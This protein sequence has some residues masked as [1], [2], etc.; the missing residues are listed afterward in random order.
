MS[1]WMSAAYVV[2]N[3]IKVVHG[4][5]SF[6]LICNYLIAVCVGQC[7]LALMIDFIPSVRTFAI[8]VMGPQDDIEKMKRLYGFGAFLDTAGIRFSVALVMIA[9]MLS[10]FGKYLCKKTIWCYIGAFIILTVI[11][12]MIARTTLVGVGLSLLYLI[13]ASIVYRNL[14]RKSIWIDIIG[15]ICLATPIVFY[16]YYTN[17]AI[18]EY[19]RFAFEG[20]FSLFETG[21]WEVGSNEILKS[22]Y[23]FPETLKTWFIGD[24]YFVNPVDIDP[25]YTGDIYG[26]YYMGTDVG[27]LRFIFYFG[28]I[29]LTAFSVF[30]Y[31]AYHICG[32]WY[33]GL[34]DLFFL[35]LAINFIVWFKV[36]TDIFLV[37][38]L[39]LMIDKKEYNNIER[40]I[41]TS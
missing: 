29:G 35:V 41:I 39:F 30:I 1:V 33:P 17:I 26:G 4:Y 9:F 28:L 3:V 10:K 37:F 21:K 12:N 7:V 32:N 18:H 27:Y 25:Y 36:S 23:V 15:F 19:I 24:G 2:C 16:F 6:P 13:Y 5:I 22:M 14:I 20:F 40:Q 31:K 38:A 11:G 8:A 34:K